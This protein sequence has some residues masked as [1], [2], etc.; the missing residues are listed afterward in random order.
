MDIQRAK[1]PSW[2][3]SI[4]INHLNHYVIGYLKCCGG[5][6][7]PRTLPPYVLR[8]ISEGKLYFDERTDCHF[9]KCSQEAIRQKIA[10]ENCL[11]WA[12][13]QWVRV[14]GQV[15]HMLE[16]VSGQVHEWATDP[17]NGWHC[18]WWWHDSCRVIGA[19]DLSFQPVL[20]FCYFSRNLM[21]SC[22]QV[23]LW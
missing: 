5:V 10:L 17:L 2:L 18:G 4:P 22:W 19:L 23:F 3:V 14:L 20:N 11:F 6:Y 8:V 13:E 15:A 12:I 16:K 9:T 21:H 7:A 1:T